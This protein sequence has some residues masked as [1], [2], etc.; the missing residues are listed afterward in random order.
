MRGKAGRGES[1]FPHST[2]SYPVA[3]RTH[4]FIREYEK[5]H[6]QKKKKED[7][8]QTQLSGPAITPTTDPLTVNCRHEYTLHPQQKGRGFTRFLFSARESSAIALPGHPTLSPRAG[9]V[10]WA[11]LVLEE[12][13]EGREESPCHDHPT[14]GELNKVPFPFA[15]SPS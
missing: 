8:S 9:W 3:R 14:L 2:L 15:R 5:N 1:E 13:K 12:E 6:H 7:Q 10:G 4:A 11:L